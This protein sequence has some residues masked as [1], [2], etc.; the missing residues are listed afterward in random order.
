LQPAY[1]NTLS[2]F[3]PNA[4]S[5]APKRPRVIDK[6]FIVVMS[7]RGVAESLRFITRTLVVKHEYAAGAPWVNSVPAHPKLIAKDAALYASELLVAYEI[8]KPHNLLPGDKIIPKLLV[9][10]PLGNGGGLF[11]K[12][13]R[14]HQD[15][16]S[17]TVSFARVPDTLALLLPR[18]QSLRS[19]DKVGNP[20][21]CLRRKGRR[22]V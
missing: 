14:Q 2:E 16:A 15:S 20:V 19:S 12:P 21:S 6:K 1:S 5:A 9:G 4:P 3:P 13:G 10:L 7:A 18:S 17:V 8:E 11:E 22:Q